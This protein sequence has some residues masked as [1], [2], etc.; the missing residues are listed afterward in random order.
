MKIMFMIK[1]DN[2]YLSLFIIKSYW[3][4]VDNTK[5]NLY[6]LM[7]KTIIIQVYNV[8]HILWSKQ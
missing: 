4:P 6:K 3:L 5:L 7:P 2:T 1:I 8:D